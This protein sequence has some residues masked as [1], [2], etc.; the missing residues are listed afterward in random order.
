MAWALQVTNAPPLLAQQACEGDHTSMTEHTNEAEEAFEIPE[1]MTVCYLRFLQRGPRWTPERTPELER[2][3][4]AHLA[5]FAK[6]HQEGTL[7]ING[8]LLNDADVVGV[9][10]FRAG[11][12]EEAQE[13]SNGDPAV[14]AGR[15]VSEVHLWM[16]QKG[17]LPE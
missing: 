5:Y 17:I 3:Q 15:L 13:L 8:P 10:V 14:Q 7:I 11:S 6:L 1:G 16:M 4:Q 2:L 12:L 9:G